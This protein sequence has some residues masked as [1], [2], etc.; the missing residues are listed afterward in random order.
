MPLLCMI[1]NKKPP[2]EK[3]VRYTKTRA[4]NS[5]ARSIVGYHVCYLTG[6]CLYRRRLLT[7]AARS[8]FF[9]RPFS[10]LPFL[11]TAVGETLLCSS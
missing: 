6:N 8:S 5:G 11:T 9:W 2:Q 10:I 7:Q 4:A 3:S 1:P